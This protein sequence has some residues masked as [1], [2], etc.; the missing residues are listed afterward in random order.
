MAAKGDMAYQAAR[1]SGPPHL[2]NNQAPTRDNSTIMSSIEA[3][4]AAIESLKPG[5]QFGYRQIAAE[6][7]CNSTTLA[8][9]HQG[10]RASCQAK[11][12]NEQAL[13]Q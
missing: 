13:H 5:E 6:Y 2:D 10:V 3:A 11:A 12:V 8:R 4:L 9:R 1:R 7:H